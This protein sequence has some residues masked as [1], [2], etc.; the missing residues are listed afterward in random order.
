MGRLNRCLKRDMAD[1][2]L[3]ATPQGSTAYNLIAR[4]TGASTPEALVLT[5]LNARQLQSLT[6]DS[7]SKVGLEALETTKRPQ[8]LGA[9]GR[10]VMNRIAKLEVERACTHFS[11]LVFDVARPF[12]SK[13]I[14]EALRQ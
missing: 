10:L 3:V 5:G 9:D 13:L 6:L 12:A 8:R 2:V 4:G 1:G 11:D 14:E 7:S